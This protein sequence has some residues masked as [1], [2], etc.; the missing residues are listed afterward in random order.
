MWYYPMEWLYDIA[1]A[2]SI[3]NVYYDMQFLADND[4]RG[5]FCETGLTYGNGFAELT[6][7]MM[8][9]CM[10]NPYMSYEE[11]VAQC[12][13]YLYIMYGDGYEIIWDYYLSYEESFHINNDLCWSNMQH[14][15]QA[16]IDI[17][18]VREHYDQWWEMY[19]KARLLCS[20]EKQQKNLEICFIHMNV[21]GIA[22]THTSRYLNGT[23]KE[24]TVIAERYTHLHEIM[25]K[26]DRR[27]TYA[28][29]MEHK[30]WPDKLD[31]NLNPLMV[32][33]INRNNTSWNEDFL[34]G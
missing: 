9:R 18:Y 24:R 8:G 2:P 26:Y 31:L 25:K 6:D 30:P 16:K 19:M 14:A 17:N 15:P 33:G 23:E 10:W 12:K 4:C 13:E 21:L 1:A 5:I 11:Y 7:Y 3:L 20:N 32:D 22:F 27:V 28:F 34:K 29:D